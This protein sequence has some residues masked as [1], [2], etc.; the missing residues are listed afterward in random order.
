MWARLTTEEAA[1][2]HCCHVIDSFYSSPAE[3]AGVQSV[4][5]AP[6]QLDHALPS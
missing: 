2:L 5:P 3:L 4:I 1:D 6:A